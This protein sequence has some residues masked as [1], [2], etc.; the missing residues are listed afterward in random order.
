MTIID[1]YNI[2]TSMFP[3]SSNYWKLEGQDSLP[4]YPNMTER[5]VEKNP[6]LI[7]ALDEYWIYYNTL[8]LTE[9]KKIEDERDK[10]TA[11]RERLEK[12]EEEERARRNKKSALVEFMTMIKNVN[13]V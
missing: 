8:R 12:E 6:L 4:F 11:S 7:M 10:D 3:P 1:V 2:D 9:L 5:H 13:N